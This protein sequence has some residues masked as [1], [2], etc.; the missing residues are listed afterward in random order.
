MVKDNIQSQKD[1]YEEIIE[2]LETHEGRMPRG[3]IRKDRKKLKK[4]DLTEKEVDEIN[5]YARWRT[6][7]LRKMLDEYA[8]IPIEKISESEEIKEKIKTLRSYELGMK[9]KTAYEEIIEWLEVHGGRLPQN[10]IYRDGRTLKKEELTEE[11]LYER[12][13]YGRWIDSQ[14]YKILKKY[15]EVPIEE[16]PESEEIKER[17]KILR[18]Y[19]L[20]KTAYVE[21]IEWLEAHE[22]KTPRYAIYEEG[23]VKKVENMTE[24]EKYKK[25]LCLRWKNSK[26]CKM[27]DEYAG[28]PIEK[29]PESEEIKKKIKT[30]RSY[31]LGKEKKSA[32]EE[33]IEWLD[34]HEGKMPRSS[35]SKDE[36]ILKKEEMS[37]E[38]NYEINLYA[39]WRNS[40]ECKMLEK[41]AEKSIEEI[42]EKWKEK[43]EK[44]RSYGLGKEKKSAYEELIEWLDNHEG[45]MPRSSISKNAKILKKEEMS[46]EEIYEKNLYARWTRTDE[47]NMLNQYAGV[48][49]D[50][51][52]ESEEIKEKI[53]T[54]RSYGLGMKEKTTYEE[55]IEWL[56][57]HEGRMPRKTVT[58]AGKALK[59]ENMTEKEIYERNLYARWQYSKERKMLNKF[60]G[61][62]IEE[63]PEEWREKIARLRSLG[64]LGKS[65][66]ERIK[67]RMKGAV[68]NRVESNEAVRKELEE[69]VRENGNKGHGE[70]TE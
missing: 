14:E 59:K 53:R 44:L 21:I 40:E 39:G 9:E 64:Q 1:T 20:G 11:E 19:G 4:E 49:I 48:P 18:N 66:D 55:I 67:G 54:L 61:V 46:E 25:N 37:E 57:N 23:K 63:V 7:K 27:L 41:Y 29:I 38:E 58:R 2:W 26:L 10:G 15:I 34:N 5:L 50:E 42:P 45:K 8:G 32:Y 51:I 22:G 31:G 65:T 16:I 28:I 56:E 60:A 6:S 33:L 70:Q 3:A 68:G 47:Y 12:N 30:L 17:I 13:L 69:I 43:I 24:D 62:P 35:I 52:Q 36:K